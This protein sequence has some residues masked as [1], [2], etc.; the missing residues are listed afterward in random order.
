VNFSALDKWFVDNLFALEWH[1]Q[2]ANLI[3]HDEK[4]SE[5][6]AIDKENLV[7]AIEHDRLKVAQGEKI[8]PLNEE[9]I[10]KQRALAAVSEYLQNNKRPSWLGYNFVE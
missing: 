4:W 2:I 9:C 1:N 10:S 7:Y 6:R 3:F 5:Y 8:A